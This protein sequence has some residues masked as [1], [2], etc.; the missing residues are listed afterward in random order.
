VNSSNQGQSYTNTQSMFDNNND[1]SF[2]VGDGDS[3]IPATQQ[4]TSP[5]TVWISDQ[6]LQTD[7]KSK[8]KLFAGTPSTQ[9][10]D[11]FENK[12]KKK[13][14]AFTIPNPTVFTGVT[15]LNDL[16]GRVPTGNDHS[17]Y[18]PYEATFVV[19]RKNITSKDF[20]LP[21]EVDHIMGVV[22]CMGDIMSSSV[23]CKV[24]TLTYI[25]PDGTISTVGGDSKNSSTDQSYGYI[26][27]ATGSPQ[28]PGTRYS[29]LGLRLAGVGLSGAV[30]GIGAAVSQGGLTT[31]SNQGTASLFTSI[32]NVPLYAAGQGINNASSEASKEFENY[33]K[34]VFDYVVARAY[35]D[36]TKSLKKFNVVI[37][38]QV[39]FDYD[40]HGR[41]LDHHLVNVGQQDMASNIF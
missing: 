21:P 31:L 29:S 37:T 32:K 41:K 15:F 23:S 8:Q 12:D 40:K 17:I 26:S 5:H 28:I 36:K 38:K 22:V 1:D 2:N 13:K 24:K 4:T 7:D 25:F 39:D 10:P 16:V 11:I 6:S 30:S 35:N 18:T 3:T 9:N 34:N 27:T 33:F 20:S 14:P 19:G